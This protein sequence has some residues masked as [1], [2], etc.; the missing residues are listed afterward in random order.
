MILD[1]AAVQRLARALLSDLARYNRPKL[2]GGADAQ[3][4]LAAELDE[5][6]ALF[7]ERVAPELHSIFERELSEFDFTR[8]GAPPWTPNTRAVAVV[9]ALVVLAIGYLMSVR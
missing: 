9:V 2:A 6:R 5:A 3:S 7:R 4:M 8:P 1:E